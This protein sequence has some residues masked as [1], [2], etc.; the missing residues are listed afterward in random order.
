MPTFKSNSLFAIVLS[1]FVAAS[2]YG[3][4]EFSFGQV[5]FF[6]FSGWDSELIDN[7]PGQTF[8]VSVPVGF[9]APV[10][11][12][13]RATGDFSVPSS[14]NGS[15]IAIGHENVG[16][17][18]V[19]EFDFEGSLPLVVS[20]LTLDPQETFEVRGVGPES[21]GHVSGSIPSL[22]STP[23]DAISPSGLL[24][25]GS[26]FGAD[27]ANGE[28]L[29]SAQPSEPIRVTFNALADSK[30]EFFQVGT[31]VV[32]EPNSPALAGIAAMVLLL[33]GRRRR[34]NG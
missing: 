31:V 24:L 12:T 19:F 30:F 5:G 26:G 33:G 14:W 20:T 25:Q 27:V 4:F 3:Q 16:E 6:D 11:V 10:T 32:P 34:R 22:M 23:A 13:V 28:I 8:D 1:L 2:S 18:S 21:Y 29:T 15:S 7:G 9:N 17:S